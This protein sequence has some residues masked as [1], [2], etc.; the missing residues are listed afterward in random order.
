MSVIWEL[1]KVVAASCNSRDML[2]YLALPAFKTKTRYVLSIP[3]LGTIAAN[4]KITI[5]AQVCTWKSEDGLIHVPRCRTVAT[6]AKSSYHPACP[7]WPREITI[8][9]LQLQHHKYQSH[10]LYH[11]PCSIHE[12]QGRSLPCAT[13]LKVW[14]LVPYA[15]TLLAHILEDQGMAFFIA[16]GLRTTGAGA[17]NPGT[18]FLVPLK[19]QVPQLHKIN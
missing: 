14:I 16:H 7:T 10:K 6:N 11:H 5:I 18:N 15:R 8:H 4:A 3:G 17:K 13:S 1:A 19:L 9:V 12:T 2:H